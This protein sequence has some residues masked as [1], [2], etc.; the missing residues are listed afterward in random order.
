M[1]LAV[2][3]AIGLVVGQVACGSQPGGGGPEGDRLEQQARQALARWDAAVAAG[4]G[5]AAFVPVGDLT[6]QIGDWANEV[7]VNNKEALLAGKIVDK[8]GLPETA[9]PLGRI[10]WA[11]GRSREV[12]VMSAALALITI[13][14]SAGNQ[15]CHGCQPLEVTAAV[16]STADIRTSRGPAKVPTW[17]FTLKGTNVRV[18]RVAVDPSAGI[19]VTAPSWDPYNAPGGLAIES[20][21]ASADGGKLEVTFTGSPD[22]GDKPC[23][24]DYTATAVESGNA[25]VIIIHSRENAPGQICQSIGARR[26]ATATLAAP[27]GERAVLEVQQGLPVPVTIAAS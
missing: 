18:T 22:T 12:P 19:T 7:G 26:T 16:L 4:G 2:V 6:G 10:E 11:D 14:R 27:L 5:I 13:Q 24:E 17:E 20:A 25:V 23:G 1:A 8:V 3:T 9:P 21:V 15:D